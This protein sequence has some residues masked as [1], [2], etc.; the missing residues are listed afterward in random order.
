MVILLCKE[1]MTAVQPVSSNNILNGYTKNEKVL[2]GSC[3]RYAVASKTGLD[4]PDQVLTSDVNITTEANGRIRIQMGEGINATLPTSIPGLLSGIAKKFPDQ[5]ALVSRPGLDGTNTTYT[6]KQYET[7]VKTVA[8]A[9]L[10]LGLERYHS[11]CI[12]G[13]NSPQWFITDIA[14]IYAG[15]LAAGI[16]TTNS[17]EACQYNAQH[18]KANIIVVEDSKQLEKILTIKKNL[19]HLKAIIQYEGIPKEK[20][21]LSWDEL[22]EIGKKESDDKLEAVLKTIGANECCTLVYTSGTVGN[23]KAVMLSH[24]NLV[25][26]SRA[27]RKYVDFLDIS[28]VWVS[29]LPLSHVAAQIVDIFLTMSVAATVYFADKNALKGSLINTLV[30]AKPTAFLGVP[31]VWEKIYEKMQLVARNNGRVK[32][33]IANWAKSQGLIYNM[34]RMNGTDYRH[35][36]YIIAKWLVFDKV[37]TTLGLNRCK[38]FVTAAAPLSVEIKKYF[39]SLDIPIMEAFGMSECSGAHSITLRNNYR[40]SSVGSVLPGFRTR[41]D[42]PNET[43]EGEICMYGRHIFMGYLNEPEKTKEAKTEEGWLHSGDLGRIDSNGLLYITGR[44]KE[45][46]ITAGGENISPL[47]IEELILSELPVLSN[48]LLIGDK[49][50]YLTVLITL[51][52]EI[53]E[54]TGDPLDTLTPSTLTWLK[55]IGSNSKT[56]SDIVNSKDP[57][58]HKEIEEAIKR[59]NTKAISNAQKVQKF[60]ILP[61]DFSISTGELGPTLKLKRNVVCNKYANLIEDMYQ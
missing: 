31:R 54:D 44:I 38:I 60:R 16:Y 48:A 50:K 41:L 58:V 39:L 6:Y 32:T 42:N 55:S 7:E 53:K 56:I 4:G 59:A 19:V 43:G 22:L 18:S 21:V 34:N 28:E 27:I 26:D 24:D 61:H 37:K 30:A 11:V 1:N 46:I 2:N 3:T 9:F 52:A 57:L 15:G 17:A 20:D 12:L 47:H 23:P 13:F 49:R 10:K 45:L 35:W 14:A 5:I 51:K 8:K 29:Y 36:G 33:W 25:H 40:L